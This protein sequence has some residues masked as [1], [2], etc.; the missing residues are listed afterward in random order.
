MGPLYSHEHLVAAKGGN[1]KWIIWFFI[2]M[3]IY[4]ISISVSQFVCKMDKYLTGHSA[5]EQW[6]L[7]NI[8][9]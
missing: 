1:W 6:D 5:T 9:Q 8:L 7:S 3:P 4:C 2:L